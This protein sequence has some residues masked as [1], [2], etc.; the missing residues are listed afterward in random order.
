MQASNKNE[1]TFGLAEVARLEGRT[2]EEIIKLIDEARPAHAD[3]ITAVRVFLQ[4]YFSAA[5][6]ACSTDSGPAQ[7]CS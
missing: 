4:T 5:A 7:P 2:T 6:H 3:M 1:R